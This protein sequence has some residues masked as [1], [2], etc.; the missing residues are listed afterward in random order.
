MDR[1]SADPVAPGLKTE[2]LAGS[3]CEILG[4]GKER[5]ERTT[6]WKKA[7]SALLAP[8]KW[9]AVSSLPGP[10]RIIYIFICSKSQVG[11]E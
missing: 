4:P 9:E 5:R 6:S 2:V 10:L 11:V 8:C 1:N 3:S 7:L